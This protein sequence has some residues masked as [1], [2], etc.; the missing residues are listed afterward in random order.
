MSY[1]YIE[2]VYDNKLSNLD[3]DYDQIV[4]NILGIKPS[5]KY[6]LTTKDTPMNFS[7]EIKEKKQKVEKVK[8]V[9]KIKESFDNN[10]VSTRECEKFLNHL[11]KCQRCRIFL[12]KKFNLD[13]KPEDI[14][15]EQYLD[16]IIFGLSGI[17]VLFLLDM[18]LNIGK[19]L[20]K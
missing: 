12:I 7:N 11:E 4:E 1:A 9:E 20:K 18:V 15:R 17:F 6:N 2:D 14:K 8:K 13:K 3:N 19:N 10:D 5:Q 16:I